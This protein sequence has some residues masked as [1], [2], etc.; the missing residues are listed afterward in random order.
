[1]LG[2][3]DYSYV[4][5]GWGIEENKDRSRLAIVCADRR[6]YPFNYLGHFLGSQSIVCTRIHYTFTLHGQLTVS[7]LCAQQATLR[8]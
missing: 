5:V 6:G 8:V 7:D 1:M 4:Y 2:L 3:F